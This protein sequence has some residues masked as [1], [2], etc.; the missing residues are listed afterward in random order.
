[1]NKIVKYV[2]IDILRNRIVLGYTLLLLI[3]SFSVF[4]LDDN[5]S[6]GTISLLNLILIIVPMVSLLFSTIYVYNSTEFIELLVTQPLKRSRIWISILLGLMSSLCIAFFVGVGLPVLFF[7]NSLTGIALIVSGLVLTCIFVSLA[8]LASVST[9]DKAKGIGIAILLWFYFT[10]IYD[11]IVLFVLFQFSDYPME[12]PMIFF[13]ALNPID[14]ARI[15]ILLKLDISALMGYTGAVLK[16]FLGSG[17]GFGLT[18]SAMIIW[19]FVPA[20][21]SLRRFRNKDL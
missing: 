17:W 2:I 4:S 5:A 6:R 13:T 7:G 14:L 18:F 15:M 19:A 10:I 3:V 12:R 11:G 20:W 16:D 9:R 1:M 8:M 21:L